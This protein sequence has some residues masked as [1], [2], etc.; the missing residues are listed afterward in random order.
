MRLSQMGG[1]SVPLGGT[2]R[3]PI[4][5]PELM[6]VGGMTFVQ[7]GY[8]D[9]YAAGYDTAIELAPWILDEFAVRSVQTVAVGQVVRSVV[10]D[11]AK[12]LLGLSQGNSGQALIATTDGTTVTGRLNAPAASCH[13]Y[14]IA[15][16]GSDYY[17]AVGTNGSGA[18]CWGSAD[19]VTWG[20]IGSPGGAGNTCSSIAT[21]GAGTWVAVKNSPQGT[22]PYY[23][24]NNGTSWTAGTRSG[25]W[26]YSTLFGVI[27]AGGLF[28]VGGQ[29]AGGW[30]LTSADGI[31]W[32]QRHTGGAYGYSWLYH[33]GSRFYANNSNASLQS[34]D[35][36]T[37][38]ASTT[39]ASA[40]VGRIND[41][42]CYGAGTF[43]TS[44]D[45]TFASR[46]VARSDLAGTG[47]VAPKFCIAP[48]GFPAGKAGRP[49]IARELSLTYFDRGIGAATAI[50]GATGENVYVRVK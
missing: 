38:T 16:N 41:Q 17:I 47:A 9:D 28:V 50:T 4:G 2:A 12:L 45:E 20:A 42:W 14:D 32:T 15:Y 44:H 48:A 24:T 30:I 6:V 27:Y 25:G 11:G 34:A 33:D 46:V 26:S 36:L 8:V 23:S 1:D 5:A 39:L 40:L 10:S 31:T 21:D 49:V 18:Y 29:E 22:G 43:S 37:W 3:F 35:G 13:V 19:G 7:S